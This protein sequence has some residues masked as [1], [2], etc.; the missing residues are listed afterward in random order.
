MH[1]DDS[2]GW[3]GKERRTIDAQ[4]FQLMSETRQM[5]VEQ[6]KYMTQHIEELRDDVR[7]LRSQMSSLQQSTLSLLEKMP[8]KLTE[9]IEIMLDDAFPSDPD[10]P[11]ATPAEKRKLHRRYHAT[12]IKEAI[13][14]QLSNRSIRDKL[15]GSLLEKGIL[16]LVTALAVYLGIGVIK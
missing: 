14:S 3:S 10:I 15:I 6:E 2:P 1:Q 9:R 11:D 5:V 4:A 8:D 16:I 13:E 7:Q 12:L